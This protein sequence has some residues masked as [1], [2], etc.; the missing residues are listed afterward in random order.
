MK[1]RRRNITRAWFLLCAEVHRGLAFV[2]DWRAEG[3][4][5]RA[6]RHRERARDYDR[7]ANVYEREPTEL[8]GGA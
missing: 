8:D 2:R 4:H 6:D 5:M 1:L 7:R 3:N